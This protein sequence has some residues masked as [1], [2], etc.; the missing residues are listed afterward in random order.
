MNIDKT[1]I[2]KHN[3]Q[4]VQG[5]AK[6]HRVFRE[7]GKVAVN[8]GSLTFAS[9]VLGTIIRGDYDRMLVLL[10]GFGGSIVLITLGVICLTIGGEE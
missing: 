8:F 2:I 4:R 6:K 3:E 1:K 5:I 7:I 10:G 9:L